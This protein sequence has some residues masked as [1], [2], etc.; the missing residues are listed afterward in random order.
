M[1][2]QKNNAIKL[3][4][5]AKLNLTLNI[6]GKRPDGYHEI[7]SVMQSIS[8]HDE[9]DMKTADS[10]IKVKCSIPGIEDNIVQKAAELLFAEAKIKGGVHIQ[11]KKNIPLSAGLG[12][13]SADAAATLIGLNKL[14]NLNLH[15][16]RLLEIAAKIGSDV[17][18][19]LVGGTA[20]CT[21]R[22]EKMERI[23]PQTGSVFLLAIPKIE[24]S[25]KIVYD[26]Y[27]EIGKASSE[28]ALEGAAVALFP[29]IGVMKEALNRS[30]EQGWKMS[31]SG[32]ALYL[33]LRDLSYADKYLE[34]LG[35][36][37][38]IHH[39]VKRMDAGV[40]IF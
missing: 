5:Y 36:F 28:N 23:N 33:E 16:D 10:G 29:E 37:E 39:V 8:L 22:G 15:R 2:S 4:A 19:C 9:I 26:K 13:G 21:G 12:G 20:R 3:R 18:F 14:F 31:G 35:S 34:A 38:V 7:D 17:P 30:T 1:Q 25:T 40:E 32:P 6:T 27:D 24:V 11:I